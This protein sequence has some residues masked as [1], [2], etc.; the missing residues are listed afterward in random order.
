MDSP[1]RLTYG[2]K[3]Q[4]ANRE[5]KATVTAL[6]VTIAVWIAGGFGLAG[7]GIEVF[8][9]PLW[10][11]GGTLGTWVCAIA[12]SVFLSR[13]VFV[14]FSF[15]EEVDNQISSDTTAADGGKQIGHE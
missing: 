9:T 4:Q 1:D 13:R 5:A 3:M 15:D 12:V 2:Q 6:V 10:V 7:T 8:H 14:D 11:I